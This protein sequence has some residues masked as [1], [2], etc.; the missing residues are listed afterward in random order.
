MSKERWKT[1]T[2][3]EFEH[4]RRAL[5]FVKSRFPDHD[6]Y[7]AWSNF[8]FHAEDGALYEVDLLVLSKMGFWLV[9]AKSWPGKIEGDVRTW[10]WTD[11]EG[12]RHS[13]DNPYYLANKKAKALAGILRKTAAFQKRGMRLPFLDPLIFL[14]DPDLECRLRGAALNHVCLTDRD[15]DDPKGERPGI[16]AALINREVQGVESQPRHPIDSR[17]A[18]ALSQAMEQAGIRPSQKARRVG[19]YILGDLI[20]DGKGYQDRLAEHASMEGVY[21]RVR[22]YLLEQASSEE[23]RQRLKRAAQR[24]FKILQELDHSGIL[25]VRDY[26]EHE[27]GPAILFHYEPKAVRLDQYLKVNGERLTFDQKTRLLERI[28]D[29]LRYAHQKKVVHRAL[30]PQCVL[31]MDPEAADPEVKLFNWQLALREASSHSYAAT[32]SVHDMVEAQTAV[33]MAPEAFHNPEAVSEASDIFSLGAIAY[34]LFSGKPP[35]ADVGELSDKLREQKGLRLS[36][37]VDGAG[38]ELEELIQWST[39]PDVLS[40][41]GSVD[42]FLDLFQRVIEEYT[43]PDE[44]TVSDPLVAQPGDLLERGF[45]MKRAMGQGSTAKGLLVTRGRDGEEVVLK[46]ARTDA[47][48]ERLRIEGEVLNTVRSEFIVGLIE[49]TEMSGRMVLVLEKA[50][51]QT[52]AQRLRSEGRCSLDLLQRFGEDL[53]QAVGSLERHGVSHRDIKP[54]NIGVRSLSKQA[55]QLV[56]FDFSLARAPLE[57]IQVGTYQYRDPFL[58]QRPTKRWDPAAERYSAGVTLYEMA[59][60]Q[61]PVWGDGKSDPALTDDELVLD[62]EQFDPGVRE[63]LENFFSVALNRDSKARFD[64]AQEMLRA[65]QETFEEAEKRTVTTPAGETVSVE[66]DVSDATPDTLVA[67]LDLSTRARNALERVNVIDVRGLLQ[68]PVNQILMLRGVGHKTRREIVSVVTKLREEF[69][70]ILTEPEVRDEEE[71]EAPSLDALFEQLIGTKAPSKKAKDWDIRLALLGLHSK[72][73]FDICYW[74]SQSEVGKKVDPSRARVGQVLTADRRRWSRAPAVTQLRNELHGELQKAGGVMTPAEMAETLRAK[75]TTQLEGEAAR[76]RASAV[77]RLAVEAEQE[78]EEP[79]MLI[80]RAEGKVLVACSNELV[81]YAKRL[82]KEADRIA[83]E[84]PLPPPLRVFQRLYDVQQPEFPAGVQS[85]GNE[86]LLR[87]AEAASQRAAVSSRQELYPRGMKA[88]RALKLGVG[89][90]MGLGLGRARTEKGRGTFTVEEV[91][92]RIEARYPEAERLPAPPEL[93]RL[94]NDVGLAVTWDKSFGR[95]ERDETPLWPTTGSS[96]MPRYPTALGPRKGEVT[97]EEANAFQFEDKLRAAIKNGSFLVLTV[98]PSE[99]VPCEEELTR[100]FGLERVSCDGV[101]LRH[102]RRAAEEMEVEWEVIRG[103]DNSDPDSQDWKNLLRLVGEVVPKVEGEILEKG[104]PVLLVHPGLVARY[105]CMALLEHL[106]DRVGQ[107]DTC[108][109][110]WVLVASDEQTELPMLDGKAIPL[111]SPGQRARVPSTWV[112]NAHRGGVG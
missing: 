91:R 43:A 101:M 102:L 41:I 32:R 49:A 68:F 16:M 15:K 36:S 63:G 99:M 83:G 21:C 6:P 12:R 79:R 82:G 76:Q 40:R 94:L 55:L 26:R 22:Q 14:A 53:L 46:V 72:H 108:P 7:R 111:I 38:K 67:A 73:Q 93:E 61:L 66:V 86:R 62:V 9:E 90:L 52:L 107:P 23:E 105:D 75:R 104:Q 95:F 81:D 13:V 1:I 37:A 56:L 103:A 45:V 59:T 8:E 60:A 88:D 84:D 64:N 35:A 54:D 20:D 30:G 11:G 17:I 2:I 4:E 42:D 57:S 106:R 25:T 110:L 39:H 27:Y 5:D 78:R 85:P 65:W 33:Y 58:S 44:E 18:R 70:T 29:S 97:P 112:I 51:D 24:E 3:S 50:G 31:V 98:K 92:Q 48:N 109:G 89:A 10:T 96:L 28:A 77:A 19:D 47:D 69:P 74:P 100:R 71:G 80:R 34:L 87:L